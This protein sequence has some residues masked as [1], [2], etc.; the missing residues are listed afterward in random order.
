MST[1]MIPFALHCHCCPMVGEFVAIWTMIVV[2]DRDSSNTMMSEVRRRQ[3]LHE[4]DD[5]DEGDVEVGESS[6]WP[7][8]EERASS[9]DNRGVK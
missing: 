2:L 9:N 7:A 1:M 4:E 8:R 3:L 6:S 5:D